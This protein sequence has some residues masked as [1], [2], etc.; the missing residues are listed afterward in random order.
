M[1]K[2]MEDDVLEEAKKVVKEFEEEMKKP[3][4]KRG[5]VWR[6]WIQILIDDYE[7]KP[8]GRPGEYDMEQ[9]AILK[10]CNDKGVY[11]ITK[12]MFNGSYD[13]IE[14]IKKR[15]QQRCGELQR[16]R[17]MMD[18]KERLHDIQVSKSIIKQAGRIM[19]YK[20]T[21]GEPGLPNLRMN[22]KFIR[23]AI[24]ELN[25]LGFG[26]HEGDDEML[27]KLRRIH[28]EIHRKI[29]KKQQFGI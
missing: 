6:K 2:V 9:K 28:I 5:K 16:L 14:I 7:E 20:M 12:E 8:E 10:K 18:E 1:N 25:E 13:E 3:P 11:R 17:G 19:D 27:E 4:H 21:Y 22:E 24:E 15:H 23:K 26:M 29:R